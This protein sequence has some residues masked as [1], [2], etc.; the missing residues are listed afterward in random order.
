MDDSEEEEE[1][2]RMEL[3][4]VGKVWTK[5]NINSNAFMATMKNVWQPTHGLDISSIGG[6]MF[7][8]Q[9]RHWRDQ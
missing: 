5:R 8:F 2:E 9:F 1:E 6:N 4:L 3:G 7:V